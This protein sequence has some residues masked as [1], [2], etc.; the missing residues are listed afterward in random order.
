ML[1]KSKKTVIGGIVIIG[2]IAIASIGIFSKSQPTHNPFDNV[3]NIS[4]EKLLDEGYEFSYG[5]CG[6]NLYY[7][8]TDSSEIYYQVFPTYDNPEQIGDIAAKG[9]HIVLDT[10][11]KDCL[12][13]TYML[14]DTTLRIK[15][16]SE[17]E[18]KWLAVVDS[19]QNNYS[20]YKSTYDN[21][22]KIDSSLISRRLKAF[23]VSLIDTSFKH[24][25]YGF[26]V[27]HMPTDSIFLCSITV[28]Y[29]SSIRTINMQQSNAQPYSQKPIVKFFTSFFK[30]EEV[31]GQPQEYE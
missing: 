4:I 16:Y 14:E 13:N 8:T 28:S 1:L 9:C 3:F 10:L 7:K 27:R 24:G 15:P 23:G 21:L 29:T 18:Y 26:W 30:K 19:L 2:V 25:Q 5:S 31:D 20:S 22:Y 12:A 6:Y 17:E 11:C